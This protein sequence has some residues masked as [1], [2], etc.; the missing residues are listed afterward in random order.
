MAPLCPR[1]VRG[2]LPSDHSPPFRCRPQ[3]A[4]PISPAPAR[5][6]PGLCLLRTFSFVAPALHSPPSACCLGSHL[7]ASEP[8][9]PSW[10]T[11]PRLPE[12]FSTGEEL[13]AW[14]AGL[15]EHSVHPS[16]ALI[17]WA[18]IIASVAAS[19]SLALASEP[20]GRG[21]VCPAPALAPGRYSLMVNGV[22]FKGSYLGP[23][24]PP[25]PAPPPRPRAF[26]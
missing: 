18:V 23:G 24:H 9:D 11:P 15:P 22:D 5:A 2:Q 7:P 6:C 19:P 20:W 25:A 10:A 4:R 16:Q 14:C 12:S 17:A 1:L 21:A 26:Q 3:P 8:K 13:M